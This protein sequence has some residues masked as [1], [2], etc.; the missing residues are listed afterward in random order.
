[1]AVSSLDQE[2]SDVKPVLKRTNNIDDTAVYDLDQEYI[3]DSA[4]FHAYIRMTIQHPSGGDPKFLITELSGAV[5]VFLTADQP[6]PMENHRLFESNSDGGRAASERHDPIESKRWSSRKGL[7]LGEFFTELKQRV[8][9]VLDKPEMKER[10]ASWE[11]PWDP[12]YYN[13]Q[14]YAGDCI[15]IISP[16]AHD[17]YTHCLMH[18][19]HLLNLTAGFGLFG[20]K[21]AAKVSQGVMK[22]NQ[23]DLDEWL[24]LFDAAT[25]GPEWTIGNVELY[26]RDCT[27]YARALTKSQDRASDH[28]EM[29][30]KMKEYRRIV[31]LE[32]EEHEGNSLRGN[33]ASQLFIDNEGKCATCELCVVQ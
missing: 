9:N 11:H 12:A 1:M 13:C 31:A 19:P 24:T 27:I 16:G 4:A 10:G 18:K 5:A 30:Q 21:L 8:R 26:W 20:S 25:P 15:S 29:H 6:E 17:F 3:R 23:P 2:T 28:S 7:T 14:H 33:V 32:E 22:D